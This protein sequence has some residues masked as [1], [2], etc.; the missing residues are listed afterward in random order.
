LRLACVAAGGDLKKVINQGKDLQILE[1][2]IDIL[3]SKKSLPKKCCDHG[4]VGEWHGYR[5]CH[6][7]PDWLLIYKID[8]SLKLLRLAR[9]GSHSD[10]FK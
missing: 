10:L 3:Q 4:L 9:T 6:I 1:Q 7:Y 2:T 8:A 5:E